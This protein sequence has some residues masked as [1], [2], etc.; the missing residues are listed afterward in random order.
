MLARG[1]HETPAVSDRRG[2]VY[3][4][5]LP[6]LGVDDSERH[7]FAEVDET[8]HTEHADAKRRARRMQ[9]HHRR[10]R[11]TAPGRRSSVDSTQDAGQR[12]RLAV[13]LP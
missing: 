5:V 3:R 8:E 4:L 2:L 6:G 11:T 13:T 9:H 10:V 12:G 7:M 1:T